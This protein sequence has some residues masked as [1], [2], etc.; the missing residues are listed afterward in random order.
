MHLAYHGRETGFRVPGKLHVVLQ[1]VL[2]SYMDFFVQKLF[3]ALS[4]PL[5]ALP[6]ALQ[7]SF[8]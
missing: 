5:Y 3:P 1:R 8:S 7:F 4:F 6:H 2:F